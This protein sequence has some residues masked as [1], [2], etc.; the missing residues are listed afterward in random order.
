MI[1]LLL[2]A[3]HHIVNLS[4]SLGYFPDVL[5][6]ACVTP[7]IKNENLD[8]DNIKNFRPVS[9]LPFLGKIIEKCV[10]LQINTYLCENSLYDY[11]QS[12]YRSS[13]SCETAFV[14]IHYDILSVLDAKSN[15]VVLLFDLSDAFD[16]VKH[17]LMLSKLSTEF[18]FFDV[19]LGWFSTYLN[20]RIY[21]LKGAGCTF[22]TVDVKSGV[23]QGS[24]LGP[25]LFNLYFK[26]A[27]LIANSHGLFVH[28][29][30]DDMQCYPSFDKDF[31]VDMIKNKIRAFLQDSKH[32]MICNFLKLNESK[33][34]VIKIL[35]NR[36]IES[37]IISNVQIDDS[38]FF[39]MP[40]DFV[41]ILGVIFDDRLNLEKHINRVV[42][43]CYANLRN[44]GRIVSKLTKPLKV[45]LVHSLILSHSDY[46]NAL[47][48]NLPEYLLHKLTKV[49]YT[50]VRFIFGLRGSAL[51]MH[52][53][54]YSK[55]LHFLPV[56]FRIKFKIALLTHKCLHGSASPYLK[57]LIK[58]H[59]GSERYNLR[60]QIKSF[61]ILAGL[62]RSV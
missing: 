7:L 48:Y 35:S 26:S 9:N 11:S 8:D 15:A 40:N 31:C 33:N 25:V 58:S 12:A 28:S 22:H 3:I 46:C 44:L 51:R 17:D 16:T 2:P 59:S 41:K 21:F 47:F 55:S 29:Y 1:D 19:A 62:R 20:N 4:L 56:K 14:K 49:L 43:T 18:V 53:L 61:I 57:N 60:V 32:W 50:A 30:A 38:C 6:K 42:C 13:Y 5:K 27:E 24:I 10:F 45:Q 52:L 23:P 54:P 39:P 37:R 36:N 34:K